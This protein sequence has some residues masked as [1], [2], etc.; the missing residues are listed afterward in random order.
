MTQQ[1]PEDLWRD[2]PKTALEFE[3]R[4]ATEEDWLP[5]HAL[6]CN[7][8]SRLPNENGTAA[9]ARPVPASEETP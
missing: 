1:T 8:S 2:F 6:Q 4:F 5:G 9:G 3:R 7:S